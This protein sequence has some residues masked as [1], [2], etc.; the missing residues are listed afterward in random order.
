[1]GLEIITDELIEHLLKT[2]K[3]VENPK[4]RKKK[5]SGHERVTYILSDTEGNRF[6]LYLRQ[7]Y[8]T[9][10]EDAF[11]C[12]LSYILPS[13]EAFTLIRYNGPSHN[14]P[15]K[16]ENEKLGYV[17]HIHKSGKRYLEETGRAD[18]YAEATTRYSTLQGA[19]S[20]LLEDCNISGLTANSDQPSLFS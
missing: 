8:K 9:G 2:S 10:M 20:C 15:N 4:A 7:N 1:M 19:L 18:G 13:G 6:N 12:G 5:D 17:C 3:T 11:S 14:H 16:L